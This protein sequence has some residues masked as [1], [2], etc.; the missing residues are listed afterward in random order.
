M[1]STFKNI[2]YR[3]S[4]TH[5]SEVT[6]ETIDYVEIDNNYS[7]N[8]GEMFNADAEIVLAY[9][10]YEEFKSDYEMAF[11]RRMQ[12]YS[13]YYMFDTDSKRV[14]YFYTDDIG[15]SYASYWGDFAAGITINWTNGQGQEKFIYTGNGS[16]AVL[17]DANGLEW[18]YIETDLINAQKRL[19][20]Q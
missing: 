6:P 1:Q 9:W 18:E 16:K 15:V 11:V 5:D 7:Y 2:E 13:I 12:N 17:I 8:P 19:D 14:A 3:E 10:V 4:I 20:E